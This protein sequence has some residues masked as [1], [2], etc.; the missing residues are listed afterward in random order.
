M[1]KLNT[2]G[3]EIWKKVYAPL[4]AKPR[5]AQATCVLPLIPGYGCGSIENYSKGVQ[6][7]PDAGGSGMGYAV[8][9]VW[10]IGDG[11][12]LRLR[13]LPGRLIWQP[14][15]NK[16]WCGLH[17]WR[18][19][20]LW[21]A[22]GFFIWGH[23]MGG[24]Q[25]PGVISQGELMVFTIFRP[26]VSFAWNASHTKSRLWNNGRLTKTRHF[27]RKIQRYYEFLCLKITWFW[28]HQIL[29][30]IEIWKMNWV[31]IRRLLT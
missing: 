3:F 16:L 23:S 18:T 2:I 4:F 30:I 31:Q 24:A 21:I 17:L 25:V 29:N 15:H 10:K 14:R 26:Q 1:W 20:I 7:T 28:K 22:F 6:R 8:V 5:N 13:S 9:T 11:R 12:Q 27:V 19:S